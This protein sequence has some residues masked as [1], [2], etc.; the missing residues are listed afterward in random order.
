MQ[1]RGWYQYVRLS[2]GVKGTDGQQRWK[3]REGGTEEMKT[4][5]IL[6]L[7]HNDQRTCRRQVLIVI[8]IV[9]LLLLLLFPLTS[10]SQSWSAQRRE[11][12]VCLNLSLTGCLFLTNTNTNTIHNTNMKHNMNTR[13][14]KD[15]KNTSLTNRLPFPLSP[16]PSYLTLIPLTLLVVFF[17][18]MFS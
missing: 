4:S 17:L 1:G 16:P 18:F 8:A 3:Q 9:L 14:C 15:N 12:G 6:F 11:A 7:I 2:V 5:M 13:Q 10:S